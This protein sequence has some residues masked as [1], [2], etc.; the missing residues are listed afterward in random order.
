[1]ALSGWAWWVPA[2]Q[3]QPKVLTLLV[4]LPFL[5][6]TTDYIAPYLIFGT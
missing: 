4:T 6:C 3:T 5:P 2:Q 1:M